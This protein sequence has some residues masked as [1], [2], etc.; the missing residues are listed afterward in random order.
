MAMQMRRTSLLLVTVSLLAIISSTDLSAQLA[1]GRVLDGA[2]ESPVEGAIVRL[3]NLEGQVVAGAQTNAE[4]MFSVQA[5]Q[6][7]SYYLSV[8]AFGYRPVVD[9]AFELQVDPLEATVYVRV[10]PVVVQGFEA[11]VEATDINSLRRRDFIE[12]QGFFDRK[13]MG[14]GHFIMADSLDREPFGARDFAM[15][16][17]GLSPVAASQN[18]LSM[19]RCENF[20]GWI[21][22]IRVFEGGAWDLDKELA[23]A[24]VF[25]IEI[26]PSIARLPLQYATFGSCG[27]ILVWSR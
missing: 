1:K 16:V 22:G 2:D 13:Q 18:I 25:A 24:D 15:G 14:Q 20:S 19:T 9:G 6:R 7:G 8:S 27:A 23:P 17:M 21:N 26:Y 4:G 10:Q 11:A 3:L 12:R 5:P